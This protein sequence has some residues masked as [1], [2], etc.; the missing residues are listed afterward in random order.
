MSRT[1]NFFLI[2]A[3]K[4]GTSSLFHYVCQHPKV[5]GSRVKE[6]HF[7]C[8]DDKY[9]RGKKW[10][11]NKY[12]DG[13][14]GYPARGEATPHYLLLPDK[15]APRLHEIAGNQEIRLI[16]I[17]RDPVDRAWSQYLFRRSHMADEGKEFVSL[18]RNE[19]EQWDETPKSGNYYFY[20]G[21]YG[22]QV[23]HWLK[24]FT[25]GSFL[26]LKLSDLSYQPHNTVRRVFEF[27]DISS[28]FEVDTDRQKNVTGKPRFRSLRKMLRS[29]PKL[30]PIFR[31]LVPLHLQHA[32]QR[33]INQFF[34]AP[35][36]QRKPQLDDAAASKVRRFYRD[37]LARFEELTGLN[38]SEWIS[39]TP[40]EMS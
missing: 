25:R 9:A 20:P 28:D 40:Q 19:V 24:Y 22:F 4:A 5:Y 11:L 13:A 8:D 29:I 7:L 23:E 21:L 35:Y 34:V 30:R 15:V 17:F 14:A 33:R 38:V 32:V 18:F 3:P 16:A 27:L 1:P 26:F 31:A 12:F 6:T 10:Y 37:D 2:G 39:G 36:D